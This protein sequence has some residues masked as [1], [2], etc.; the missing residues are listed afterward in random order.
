MTRKKRNELVDMNRLAMVLEMGEQ[1]SNCIR[2]E[3]FYFMLDQSNPVYKDL[4]I[5]YEF[6]NDFVNIW[7]FDP[8]YMEIDGGYDDWHMK[9][10]LCGLGTTLYKEFDW[11]I[12]SQLNIYHLH[13]ED[14]LWFLMNY[15]QEVGKMKEMVEEYAEAKANNTKSE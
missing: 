10:D 9:D 12:E 3:L 6:N 11:I 14:F 13:H 7:I 15:D 2:A 1:I 4:D 5:V 8:D